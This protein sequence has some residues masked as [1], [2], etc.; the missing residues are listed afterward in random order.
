MTR[1]APIM[2]KIFEILAE[3]RITEAVQR[4]ELDNLPG[5]GRPLEF[6]EE[7]FVSPEQR[8]MNRVLKQAGFTPTEVGLR[9]A[10][11]ELR[12]EL[13]ATPPGKARQA[14]QEKLAWSLLQLGEAG[15]GP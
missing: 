15:K 10:I 8:M 3:R 12:Q 2:V 11:G 4:G 9:R 13:A 7:P 6:E 1:S 14:L 5:A